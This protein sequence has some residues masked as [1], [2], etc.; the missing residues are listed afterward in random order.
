MRGYG[1]RVPSESSAIRTKV[2]RGFG[3]GI[4]RVARNTGTN[5]LLFM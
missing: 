4:L 5:R 3:D 2:R 1:R